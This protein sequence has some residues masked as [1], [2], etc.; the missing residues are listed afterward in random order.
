MVSPVSINATQPLTRVAPV[1]PSVFTVPAQ[2]SPS[3]SQ[4]SASY[5]SQV[6]AVYLNGLTSGATT[7]SVLESDV[8]ASVLAQPGDAPPEIPSLPPIYGTQQVIQALTPLA[9]SGKIFT[10]AP[11]QTVAA[12][13]GAVRSSASHSSAPVATR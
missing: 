8:Y 6:Y 2:S 3:P 11:V 13:T 7:P 4:F 5:P 9:G 1:S 12:G 10:G